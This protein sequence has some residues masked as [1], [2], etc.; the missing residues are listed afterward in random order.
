MLTKFSINFFLALL[1]LIISSCASV[2]NQMVPTTHYYMD[3]H[4]ENTGGQQ[5][6]GEGM[7]IVESK[8]LASFEFTS[9]GRLDLITVKTCS[10][11][12]VVSPSGWIKGKKFKYHYRR[13]EIEKKPAC[14][15]EVWGFD[16]KKGQHALAWVIFE[17]PEDKL[18]ATVVCGASTKKFDGTS[19]CQAEV[20]FKQKI[21]FEK[22]VLYAV[23]DFCKSL[24]ESD[25]NMSFLV[26][27]APGIC[28]YIFSDGENDHRFVG[29]GY[30]DTMVRE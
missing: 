10:R 30:T 7:L 28:N 17:N 26:T 8:D 27:F 14:D 12:E 11:S 2:D 4:I 3:M 22:P 15:L 20:G 25:D 18:P 24:I 5:R 21:I 1:L 6:E 19:F 16:E 29:Y 13:N 9:P 23:T